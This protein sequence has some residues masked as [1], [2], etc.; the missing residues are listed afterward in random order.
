METDIE[1]KYKLLRQRRLKYCKEHNINPRRIMVA[2][3]ELITKGRTG[4]LDMNK[5]HPWTKEDFNVGIGVLKYMYEEIYE[6]SPE[7]VDALWRLDKGLES[8]FLVS[9]VTK[10]LVEKIVSE[11]SDKILKECLFNDKKIILKMMYPEYY[12][13]TYNNKYDVMTDIVNASGYTLRDLKDAGRSKTAIKGNKSN[14]KG[15]LVDSLILEGFEAYFNA[16]GVYDYSDK[17]FTLSRAKAEKINKLGM[18]KVLE[19]RGCYASALD[20][21]YLNSPVNFQ[22]EH[23]REYIRLRKTSQ[24]QDEIT[25]LLNCFSNNRKF[26]DLE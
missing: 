15:R 6:L 7:K 16:K 18:I 5:M 10:N 24:K 25:N 2:T 9:T 1:E 12:L 11:S 17:L 13:L 20:F 14:S 26:Y 21:Y 8:E 22:K 4:E 19:N 23:F 3:K